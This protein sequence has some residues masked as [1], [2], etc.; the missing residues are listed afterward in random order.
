MNSTEKIQ[1]LIYVFALIMLVVSFLVIIN[2]VGNISHVFNRLEEIVTKETILRLERMEKEL[3]IEQETNKLEDERKRRT[4]ALLNVPLM[5]NE[6]K[7][8]S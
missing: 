5:R 1:I 4:E 2:T 6:N 3:K 8:D 7:D